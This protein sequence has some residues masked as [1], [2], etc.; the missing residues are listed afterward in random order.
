[1][2]VG[3]NI[4]TFYFAKIVIFIRINSKANHME[5]K[6]TKQDDFLEKDGKEKGTR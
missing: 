3:K 6:I 1:M 4:R 2:G 5:S